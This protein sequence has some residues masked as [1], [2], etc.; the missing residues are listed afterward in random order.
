MDNIDTRTNVW[1]FNVFFSFFHFFYFL[2]FSVFLARITLYF[3]FDSTWSGD[4]KMA[5]LNVEQ[6]FVLRVVR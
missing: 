2:F 3:L 6:L 5:D 4:T 1:F